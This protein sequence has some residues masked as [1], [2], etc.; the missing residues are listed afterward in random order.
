METRLVMTLQS[1]MYFELITSEKKHSAETVKHQ[2]EASQQ[3]GRSSGIVLP[4]STSSTV[5]PGTSMQHMQRHT[6]TPFIFQLTDQCVCV[7]DEQV[8]FACPYACWCH[9][10]SD[11]SSDMDHMFL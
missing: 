9:L 4:Y 8:P 7:C 6:Q 3:A 1:D 11:G 10:T 2:C 5:T